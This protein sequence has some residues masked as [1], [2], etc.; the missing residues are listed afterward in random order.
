[1][2]FP[3]IRLVLNNVPTLYRLLCPLVDP[4]KTTVTLVPLRSFSPEGEPLSFGVDY[5]IIS[6]GGRALLFKLFSPL[7]SPL[8]RFVSVKGNPGLFAFRFVFAGDLVGGCWNLCS[9][10]SLDKLVNH[11][12]APFEFSLFTF[13][14]AT[15]LQSLSSGASPY[16]RLQGP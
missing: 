9:I 3:L 4:F 13:L 16:V 8:S 7:R 1:L 6:C 14:A 12:E 2:S 15:G 11:D 5:F 10:S